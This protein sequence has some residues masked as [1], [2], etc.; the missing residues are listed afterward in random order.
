L[1]LLLS[2][3]ISLTIGF[4]K[5]HHKQHL[6][7]HQ[8]YI[9]KRIVSFALQLPNKRKETYEKTLS[10]I[11]MQESSLGINKI[12][13]IS[14]TRDFRK[15]SYGLFQFQLATVREIAKRE[16]KL[17]W[18]L[19][20]SDSWIAN[21]LLRDDDFSIILAVYHI[22][23]LSERYRDWR[24]IVCAWNGLPKGKP[25]KYY[26]KVTRWKRLVYPI[27]R[28]VLTKRSLND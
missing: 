13:D 6:T 7:T 3:L 2:L 28:K 1:R 14:R 20:K 15:A 8:K 26:Y 25:T 16:P 10:L 11:A 22:K 17:R 4:A 19:K 18:L 12:G 23:H 21:K 5:P 24:Y 9:I 27:V